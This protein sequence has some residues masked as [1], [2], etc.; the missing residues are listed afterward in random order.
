MRL[1]FSTKYNM[2]SWTAMIAAYTQQAEGPEAIQLF[3]RMQQEGV[4]PSKVTYVCVLDACAKQGAVTVEYGLQV[5]VCILES[6]LI[7]DIDVR[8]S[9]INMYGKC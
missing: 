5:H 6:R 8:I 2:F 4:E 1:K 7:E 3:G 9:L